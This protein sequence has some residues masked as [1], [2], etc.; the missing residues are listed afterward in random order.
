MI[1]TCYISLIQT[2]IDGSAIMSGTR[3]TSSENSKEVEIPLDDVADEPI[4]R[5]REKRY[6]EYFECAEEYTTFDDPDPS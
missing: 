3:K 5:I 6:P 4:I 1:M 2:L